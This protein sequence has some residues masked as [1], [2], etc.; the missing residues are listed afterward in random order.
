M[1]KLLAWAVVVAAAPIGMLGG[2]ATNDLVAKGGACFQSIDCQLGLVC[3]YVND[4]GSCTDDLSTINNPAE[5]G[6]GSDVA[7]QDVTTDAP[8]DQS[9]QDTGTQDTG[10]QDT[11]TQDTGASDA[12]AS[13][14]GA[15]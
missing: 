14:A 9:V 2:C 10:T 12:G 3:V 6:G 4:A 13:D 15:G 5:A 11:G 8:A 1:K 7:Q